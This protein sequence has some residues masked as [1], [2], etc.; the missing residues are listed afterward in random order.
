MRVRHL[1]A[2]LAFASLMMDCAL[3]DS[4][5]FVDSGKEP[6]IPDGDCC[7]YAGLALVSSR[8]QSAMAETLDENLSRLRFDAGEPMSR[9]KRRR[10]HFKRKKHPEEPGPL[11]VPEPS[12]MEMLIFGGV[13]AGLLTRFRRRR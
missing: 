12:T 13:V 2:A 5:L 7:S 8:P 3:A 10:V 6:P 4:I 11:P 9:D 1:V